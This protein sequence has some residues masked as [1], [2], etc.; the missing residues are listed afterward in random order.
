MKRWLIA[1]SLL[2]CVGCKKAKPP[3]PAP[4][5]PAPAVREDRPRLLSPAEI[6]AKVEGAEQKHEEHMDKRFDE[7]QKQGE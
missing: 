7:A 3:E 1:A 5:P 4:P 2:A 6:K